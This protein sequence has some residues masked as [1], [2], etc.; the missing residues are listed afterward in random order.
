MLNRAPVA[1]AGVDQ[2]VDEGAPASLDGSASS[3]PDADPL[4][5]EWRDENDVLL[6]SDATISVSL[7]VG[8]HEITLTV[9]DGDL[10][11][12]DTVMRARRQH[13]AAGV[14]RRPLLR[15]P[16]HAHHV[17]RWRLIGC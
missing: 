12:T 10:S 5:Y 8:I 13:G 2:M 9:S 1:D 4:T 15:R 17:Q 3:D 16:E 14:R 11:A 7:A 6:G